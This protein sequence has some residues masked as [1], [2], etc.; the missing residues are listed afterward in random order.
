MKPFS[1][2]LDTFLSEKQIDPGEVLEVTA[3]DGTPN[4]IPLEVLIDTMKSVSLSEQREL[5]R[6]MVKADFKNMPIRPLLAHLAQAIALPLG[7]ERLS[8]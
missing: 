7:V 6:L 3:F 8:E 5:R 1:R 4:F 2:W